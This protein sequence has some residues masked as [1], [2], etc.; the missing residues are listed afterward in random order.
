MVPSLLSCDKAVQLLASENYMSFLVHS[1]ICPLPFWKSLPM[2]WRRNNHDNKENTWKNKQVSSGFLNIPYLRQ[3]LPQVVCQTNSWKRHMDTRHFCSTS[4]GT[5][6]LTCCCLTLLTSPGALVC[7]LWDL[8]REIP[9]LERIFYVDW[10]N[11][12]NTISTIINVYQQT[13]TT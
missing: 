1:S 4:K 5:F 9:P 13:T 11:I 6:R 7:P 10:T 2:P 8:H 3:G 12:R